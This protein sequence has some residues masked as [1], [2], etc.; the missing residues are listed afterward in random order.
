M[1]EARDTSD[2]EWDGWGRQSRGGMRKGHQHGVKDYPGLHS[3]VRKEN[4][5]QREGGK[6]QLR[7]VIARGKHSPYIPPAAPLPP[8][9]HP[10]EPLVSINTTACS[11]SKRQT[12][13]VADLRLLLIKGSSWRAATTLTLSPFNALLA[14]NLSTPPHIPLPEWP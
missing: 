8:A 14:T 12:P 13:A 10:P 7:L 6:E 11:P 5:K 2:R 3:W 4:R 9:T 1:G